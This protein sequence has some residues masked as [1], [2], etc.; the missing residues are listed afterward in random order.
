MVIYVIV[1]KVYAML[2]NLWAVIDSTPLAMRMQLTQTYLIP[3]LLYGSEI[4]GNSDTDDI[5]IS[6]MIIFS[7][8][9]KIFMYTVLKANLSPF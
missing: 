7:S 4:F 9:S 8:L 2:M 6:H 3:V 1:G 5:S